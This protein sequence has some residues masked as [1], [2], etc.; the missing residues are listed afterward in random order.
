[1]VFLQ[2]A[3][4]YNK[5]YEKV[6][7]IKSRREVF[8]QNKAIVDAMNQDP[9]NEGVR[10]KINETAD[11]TDEEYAKGLGLDETLVEEASADYEARKA[12]FEHA[13]N[14]QSSTPTIGKYINWANKKKVI[15]V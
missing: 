9:A 14:L 8:L 4:N 1:M 12:E 15:P 5:S 3:A 11:R 10:F 7:D 2:F 13:D 6:D